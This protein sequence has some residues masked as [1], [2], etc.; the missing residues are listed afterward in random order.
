MG[1]KNINKNMLLLIAIL[2]ATMIMGVGYASIEGITGEIE[3]K[4]VADAQK[5]VFITDVDYVS[6]VDANL[7]GCTINNFLGTMLNSSINFSKTNPYSE[8]KYK[9]T[10]YNSSTETV[11][12]VGVVYDDDF[13]DNPD[14]AFKITSEGFQIGEKIA[15]GE[16]KEV[17]ITFK[18]KDAAKGTIPQNT[19][20]KSYLNF[21]MAEPNRLVKAIDKKETENYL[22]STVIK[23]QSESIK[24]E[25]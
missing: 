16:T 11:P 19:T 3:G 13:Y 4:V 6:D 22:T 24:F 8:I 17:Y 2:I 9:V 12:F 10:I 7:P 23:N 15:P 20:L 25:Q 18:Y 1:R 21:K 5:G 14:I